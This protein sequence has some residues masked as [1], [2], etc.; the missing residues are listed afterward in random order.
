MTTQ[1]RR[2]NERSI[3]LRTPFNRIIDEHSTRKFSLGKVCIPPHYRFSPHQPRYPYLVNH[4][5]IEQLEQKMPR[6]PLAPFVACRVKNFTEQL[7]TLDTY[8]TGQR[9]KVVNRLFPTELLGESL[10]RIE[11][12]INQQAEAF[13]PAVAPYI[14]YI[15]NTKGKRIRPVLTLLSGG[16]TGGNTGDHMKL[17]V[18]LELIH[19]ASLIHDDIIDEAEIRR[20]A[21]T[22]NAKWGAALSVLLGDSLLSQ[23]LLLSAE[24]DDP[25]I[26]KSIARATKEVCTGEIIQ[27]QRRFDFQLSREDYFEIIR[28]K[29]ATLFASAMELAARLNGQNESVQAKLGNYGMKIGTAYQI[30]DDCL[31]L[32]GEESTVGK[33]LRT[34]LNKGKLTLPVLNLIAQASPQQRS[35]LNK[36]LIQKEA[37]DVSTLGSIADYEGAIEAAVKTAKDL[38]DDARNCLNCLGENDFT[39]AL[40]QI[41]HYLDGLLDSCCEV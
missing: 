28:L 23:A 15:C 34:D 10:A 1:F 20:Q 21:P 29:T 24:F 9:P 8:D 3:S 30:Y 35:K 5:A 14:S 13:D 2:L 40:F 12:A 16:A 26:I 4:F 27:T 41:T 39:D 37:I 38:V 36:L 11:A 19:I 6:R 32:T 22:A 25:S 18:I 7:N 33:T 17:G 31:D